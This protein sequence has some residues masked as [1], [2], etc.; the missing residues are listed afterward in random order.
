MGAGGRQAG[1]PTGKHG[2]TKGSFT[3]LMRTDAL[4]YSLT[5]IA[6]PLPW[7]LM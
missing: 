7:T 5:L 3:R 4:L 1:N 2:S 6:V